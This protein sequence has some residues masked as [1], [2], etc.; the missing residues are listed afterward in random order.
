MK[1]L[2][3]FVLFL[4]PLFGV[5]QAQTPTDA[6]MMEQ[7][8]SCFALMYDMGSWDHYWE[9]DYLITN[10][11]VGTL[12]RR[13][14]MPMIAIGLHEKVNLIITSPHVKTESKEP[15]GGKQAGV[16]GMQDIGVSLKAELLKK[17]IGLAKLAV[18]NMAIMDAGISCWDAKYFYHYPRPIQAIPGFKTILGTP[19]FPSYSSGHSTF[20]SA[21]CDVLSYIF[22]NEAAQCEKWA[23]EAAESRVYGGI[24]YR[25][26]SEVGLTQGKNVARY[27]I[28]IAKIDGAD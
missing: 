14:I 7:R 6:V 17:Q 1:K 24:H 15:N 21:A 23:F 28:D 9:G 22:P 10:G 18:L 4:F 2:I 20:S 27:T 25:F 26:D 8:K 19:N 11:N 13:T 5:L 16:S 3:L 12:T